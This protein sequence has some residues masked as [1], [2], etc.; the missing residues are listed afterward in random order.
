MR[1]SVKFFGFSRFVGNCFLVVHKHA[2]HMSYF[3]RQTFLL[4]WDPYR[5]LDLPGVTELSSLLLIVLESI[6][7]IHIYF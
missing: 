1:S 3:Y 7:L 6:L 4:M 2:T 5:C